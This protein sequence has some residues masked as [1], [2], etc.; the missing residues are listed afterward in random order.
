VVTN[1]TSA[2]GFT[3]R[4]AL[5]AVDVRRNYLIGDRSNDI[6]AGRAA[7]LYTVFPDREW[8]QAVRKVLAREAKHEGG[9]A[10]DADALVMATPVA[11][12][13]GCQPSSGN[14][15]EYTCLDHPAAHHHRPSH[16]NA[17]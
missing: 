6:V 10:A 16:L 2:Y 17:R 8:R 3:T 11:A 9:S 14:W 13:W 7:G 12:L 4:Q 15:I 1:Q 5:A